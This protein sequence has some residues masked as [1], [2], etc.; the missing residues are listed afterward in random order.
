[1]NKHLNITLFLLMSLLGACMSVEEDITHNHAYH[2][3]YVAGRTYRTKQPAFVQV[4]D[5]QR[6][7][8]AG[9]SGDARVPPTVESYW[10]TGREAWPEIVGI[11]EAGTKLRIDRIIRT[12]NGEVGNTFYVFAKV[13]DG[14]NRGLEVDLSMISLEYRQKDP[15]ADVPV[16]DPN[17]VEEVEESEGNQMLQP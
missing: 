15:V 16:S 14:P 11:L 1:M 9:G 12:Y 8:R 2:T 5:Q 3:N 6:V 4:L 13:M 10:R 17:M 7:L